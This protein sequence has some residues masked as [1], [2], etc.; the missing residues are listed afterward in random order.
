MYSEETLKAYKMK[1][2]STD[3]EIINKLI[4][5]LKLGVRSLSEITSPVEVERVYN[6]LLTDEGLAYDKPSK[7]IISNALF[8]YGKYLSTKGATGRED[9]FLRTTFHPDTDYSSFVGCYKPITETAGNRET[10][11]YRFVPQV[12]MEAYLNAWARLLSG[13]KFFLVVEEINRANCAQVFGDLF[14]LLDRDTAGFSK[15]AIKADSDIECFIETTFSGQTRLADKTKK[16]GYD[17]SSAKEL[18]LDYVGDFGNLMLPSN[19][20]IIA[21]MNTSDQS[22]YPMDSAF[23]CRWD[24]EYVSIDYEN[25]KIKD[26]YIDIELDKSMAAYKD[27]ELGDI[28]NADNRLYWRIFLK[29]INNKILDSLESSDKQLGTF[30]INSDTGVIGIEEFKSKVMFYL[31]A[32]AFRDM[33]DIGKLIDEKSKRMYAFENLYGKDGGK[34]DLRQFL[35]H[36]AERMYKKHD[37]YSEP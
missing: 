32:D 5:M 31:I 14:Q 2:V 19:L 17:L 11:S 23:K 18:Y 27:E 9:N 3:T 37:Y 22:L 8:M 24:W 30:F 10:L 16:R 6:F 26:W 36:L 15:Y 35:C 21:M 13:E 20:Y 4:D 33:P 1:L 28:L 34:D 25:P 29:A 7:K 12:F